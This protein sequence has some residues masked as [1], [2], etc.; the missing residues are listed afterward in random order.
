MPEEHEGQA[1]KALRQVSS[2]VLALSLGLS[3]VLNSKPATA[4]SVRVEDVD[5]PSMQ[6]GAHLLS[7]MRLQ[8]FLSRF[9]PTKSGEICGSE[10]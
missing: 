5:N 8:D 10:L 2:K 1:Q 7:R 3:L 6:A 9:S 4:N